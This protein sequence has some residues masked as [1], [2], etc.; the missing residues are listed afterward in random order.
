MA[1]TTRK[2]MTLLEEGQQGKV[3]TINDALTTIDGALHCVQII[4][5]VAQLPSASANIRSLAIATD[6][7]VGN[8]TWLVY[9]NGTNWIKI[10]Q[11]NGGIATA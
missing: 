10:V 2:N 8:E 1:T 4:G 5:T 11:V 3:L 9:S 6:V 7:G